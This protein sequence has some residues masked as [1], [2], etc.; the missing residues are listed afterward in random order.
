MDEIPFDQRV[1]VA[2]IIWTG[3]QLL[4]RS[5]MRSRD[6]VVDL[7]WTEYVLALNERFGEG[8]ED[9]MEAI[10]NL[11][12]TE[13]V[14]EYQ[15]EFD[16]LLAT[17]NLSTENTISC[18]LGGLQACKAAGPILGSEG[19]RKTKGTIEFRYQGKKHI[20]RGNYY[21]HL[22]TTK[23]KLLDKNCEEDTQFYVMSLIT[24]DF[25]EFAS[26]FEIPTTLPPH[27]GRYDHKIP[28]V[29]SST[30]VNKRP[31]KYP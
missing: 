1:T 18:I 9:S 10:M 31:Y 2:F 4:G 11:T 15:A 20:L 22:K 6:S 5:Y 16:R 25:K 30:P 27:R 24:G 28:L 23:S 29:E 14:K 3:K 21:N 17:V 8:F 13:C 19:W 12:Q 7:S 26:I